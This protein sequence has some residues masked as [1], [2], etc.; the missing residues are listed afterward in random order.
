M[1]DATPL[2]YY[3]WYV[4]DRLKLELIS[5]SRGLPQF[6]N[7]ASL[8]EVL[9]DMS[10]YSK[11]LD[12]L[13]DHFIEIIQQAIQENRIV[14]QNGRW[15]IDYLRSSGSSSGGQKNLPNYPGRIMFS[16]LRSGHVHIITA[17]A[18]RL[19]DPVLPG[20]HRT[21]AVRQQGDE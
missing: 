8:S 15:A 16:L 18:L 4:F 2:G 6:Y 9:Y 13:R 5:C 11:A 1:K 3:F 21:I 19:L 20:E 7:R 10:T 12:G 17:V 14:A